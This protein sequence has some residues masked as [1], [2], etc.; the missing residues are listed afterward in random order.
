MDV[1]HGHIEHVVLN[2]H[3]KIFQGLIT[4][5]RNRLVIDILN[6]MVGFIVPRVLQTI[7]EDTCQLGPIVGFDNAVLLL[8]HLLGVFNLFFK[9]RVPDFNGIRCH[10]VVIDVLHKNLGYFL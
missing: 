5:K 2:D 1:L 6:R 3:R 8:A 9:E 7:E 4:I 10:F